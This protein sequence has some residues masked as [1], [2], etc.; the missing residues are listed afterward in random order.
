MRF[1]GHQ[2]VCFLLS[3]MEVGFILVFQSRSIFPR[4][5][6]TAKGR[7][8]R[9]MEQDLLLGK[10]KWQMKIRIYLEFAA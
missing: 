2:A 4:I 7:V 1:K 8:L 5:L 6:L 3:G 9:E 10:G